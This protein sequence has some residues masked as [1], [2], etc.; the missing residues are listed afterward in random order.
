MREPVAVLSPFPAL[1]R[2]LTAMLAGTSFDPEEPDDPVAWMAA[3]GHRVVLMA[4]T[5]A[6]DVAQVVD[7][8]QGDKN[9]VV[10]A[11]L[12]EISHG[13]VRDAVQAGASSVAGWDTSSEQLLALLT[14]GL[15]SRSIVPTPV[16]QELATTNN[17]ANPGELDPEQLEWLRSL[18]TGMTVSQLAENINYSEREVYRLLRSLYERLGVCNR[19]EALIWAAQHG[20]V[21]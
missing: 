18:A 19:T 20:I 9:I 21:E 15:E 2:G 4:V 5:R 1:T 13:V 17:G 3:A 14:A 10:L 8:K 16:L 11:L 6:R 7:L 12:P